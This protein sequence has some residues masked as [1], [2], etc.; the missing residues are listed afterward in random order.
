[1]GGGYRHNIFQQEFKCW[2]IY[3]AVKK[4]AMVLAVSHLP[5]SHFFLLLDLSA[6]VAVALPAS[7]VCDMV[8]ALR[9]SLFSHPGLGFEILSRWE[10][11][12]TT[13]LSGA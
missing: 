10:S 6:A 2:S 12:T 13:G 8:S 1:M 4:R 5:T 3:L 9:I 7:L 11:T